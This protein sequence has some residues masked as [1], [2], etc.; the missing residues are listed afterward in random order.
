MWQT[1]RLTILY[2]FLLIMT[3]G[4]YLQHA[5]AILPNVI[6]GASSDATPPSGFITPCSTLGY[7]VDATLT[8]PALGSVPIT[9]QAV[10]ETSQRADRTGYYVTRDNSFSREVWVYSYDAVAMSLLSSVQLQA[11]GQLDYGNRVAA[12]HNNNLYIVRI[13]NSGRLGCTVLRR[14]ISFVRISPSGAVSDSGPIDLVTADVF[15]L[16]DLTIRASGTAYLAFSDGTGG[17]RIAILNA[18]SLSFS[19]FG[20]PLAGYTSTALFAFMEPTS[21]ALY[22]GELNGLRISSVPFGS[23]TESAQST[24]SYAGINSSAAFSTAINLNFLLGVS[25]T[26]GGTSPNLAYKDFSL[27]TT[28]ATV[29]YLNSSDGDARAGGTYYDAANNVLHSIRSDG[30]AGAPNIIRSTISPFVIQQRYSA[31]GIACS[32]ATFRTYDYVPST[33]RFYFG[34]NDF[35]NV[36]ITRVKVCNTGGPPA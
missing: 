19:G 3:C 9:N 7:N 12:V 17:R 16:N 14:C 21:P 5:N 10:V 32:N 30:G 24:Y 31:C 2:I 23:T 29:S 20:P 28:Q 34:V 13:V 6:Y 11:A 36:T 18:P 22:V 35:T 27:V 1:A 15:G 25:R 4:V 26:I 33:E 8:F